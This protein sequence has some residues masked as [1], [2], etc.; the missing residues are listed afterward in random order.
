MAEI[1][2]NSYLTIAATC[3]SDGS[4]GLFSQKSSREETISA[5]VQGREFEIVVR[6]P[7]EHLGGRKRGGGLDQ[8]GFP[9]LTR[10][11]AFQERIL[12]PRVVYFCENELVWEC[13]KLRTCE[14][15]SDLFSGLSK[16]ADHW[17]VLK[18]AKTDIDFYDIRSR[19]HEM[20]EEYTRLRLT[21]ASDLLPALSG[22][23]KQMGEFRQARYLAGLWED[24]LVMDLL[25]RTPLS[26]HSKRAKPWRAPTWSWASVDSSIT[27]R[28]WPDFDRITYCQLVWAETQH[29]TSDPTGRVLSGTIKILG[30]LKAAKLQP[31][32]SDY[33]TFNGDGSEPYPFEL[34]IGTGKTKYFFQDYD[35]WVENDPSEDF[36][37]LYCLRVAYNHGADYLLVLKIVDWSEQI[38][39]R[40]GLAEQRYH[41]EA[42]WTAIEAGDD[43][44][45]LF[46]GVIERVVTI[47]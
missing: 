8:S 18:P 9:L 10:A 7:L 2:Q 26:Q 33:P 11:W 44:H 4:K 40:V 39:E 14:C 16:K 24:N 29:A 17:K 47:V 27:Y 12:A 46:A 22:V 5:T 20:V 25:W 30:R 42:E 34:R 31:C 19:W 1:Y 15:G 36:I 21:Y 23:V 45:S 32:S 41:E 13:G 38:Y 35:I 6:R 28:S 37:P 3:A 43:Q